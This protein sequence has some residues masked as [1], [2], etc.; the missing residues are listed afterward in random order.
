M[1]PD[2]WSG[3]PS[4]GLPAPIPPDDAERLEA[5]QSFRILDNA[6]LPT[7]D[8]LV[9]LAAEICQV[10]M[11]FVSLVDKDREFF[12]SSVGSDVTE[13]PRGISFCGHAI[14]QD[15]PL[16]ISDALTDPRFAEN[17]NVSAGARVRFYAGV[18]LLSREG[19][20]LGALCVKDTVP[21]TLTPAQL[22]ALRVLAGQV[23]AQLILR[24]QLARNRANER[25]LRAN[26][27][28]YRTL[29]ERSPDLIALVELD[30]TIRFA[31]QSHESLLGY[32][33][34]ELIGSPIGVLVDS[35]DLERV[36]ELVSQALSGEAVTLSSRIR[37]RRKD[38][39]L[40]TI[41]TRVAILE[42][43]DDG[44]PLVLATGRDLTAR[45]VLEDKYRHAEKMETIGQLT[46]SIAHDFNNLLVPML[47]YAEL[48][49]SEIRGDQPNL[50][51]SIAQIKIAAVAARELIGQ[52]LAVG[53]TQASAPQ[54]L[55]L[56]DAVAKALPLV[57]MLLGRKVEVEHAPTSG[58]PRCVAD[59]GRLNQVLLNLAANAR[60]VV[61]ASGGL[62]RI[63]TGRRTIDSTQVEAAGLPPGEYVTLRFTD[64]GSGMDDATKARVFEPF[65]TTKDERGTGLGLSAVQQIVRESGGAIDVESAPA[66]GTS[67]VMS[68]PAIATAQ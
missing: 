38:G 36:F 8:E 50:R 11:A 34:E 59:P 43:Q 62:V 30:G 21:R 4:G 39:G 53:R 33:P 42:A 17:P 61:P 56:D 64:N 44:Q 31:S 55:S 29:V 18:P 19:F 54:A 13:S 66:Q 45:V 16:V 20:A 23:E 3:A 57:R 1:S 25:T 26:R 5:L 22:E 10:P 2:E 46:G 47:G 41:E 67:F 9:Q 15:E 63:A 51:A 32:S 35:A 58:L 7:F 14:L 65:F 27:E 40:L 37:A 68:L 6:P 48:A 28:L 52:L 24:R 12:L 49:L 60:D